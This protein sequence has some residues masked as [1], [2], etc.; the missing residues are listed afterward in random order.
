MQYSHNFSFE[1][2]V[3]GA[4]WVGLPVHIFTACCPVWLRVRRLT[5]NDFC[6][7]VN[8][9]SSK[10]WRNFPRLRHEFLSMRKDS[11]K[12]LRHAHAQTSGR[13]V[14]S[15]FIRIIVI[16]FR[17]YLSSNFSCKRN[18]KFSLMIYS[19]RFGIDTRVRW[20]C[21]KRC[22]IVAVTEVI[23]GWRRCPLCK[24]PQDVK[25]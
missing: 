20:E 16:F 3:T 14:L 15:S 18:G 17:I 25:W 5:F 19:L 11:E 9:I 21:S 2:E 6:V 24:S 7:S 8:N 4:A 10:L 12:L 22:I 23:T 13:L 1:E